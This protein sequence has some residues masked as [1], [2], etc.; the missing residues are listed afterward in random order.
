MGEPAI[1]LDEKDVPL[2][3]LTKLLEIH[4]DK[5]S[6]DVGNARLNIVLIEI[7]NNIVGIVVD[8]IIGNKDILVKPISDAVHKVDYFSGS[9]L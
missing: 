4:A 9:T 1:I 3:Y 2:I 7:E 8:S 6:C 5:K